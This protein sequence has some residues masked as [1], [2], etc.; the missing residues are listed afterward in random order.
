VVFR[1]SYRCLRP[2]IH[3]LFGDGGVS[4]VERVGS[5]A[6]RWSA[7]KVGSIGDSGNIVTTTFLDGEI[8]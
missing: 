2:A 3:E 5:A 7:K 1:V 6:Q 8:E 4:V